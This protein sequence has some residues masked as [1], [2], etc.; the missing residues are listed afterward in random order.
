V[1]ETPAPPI[2]EDRRAA[3]VAAFK[4]AGQLMHK[5]GRKKSARMA[6]AKFG[7]PVSASTAKRSWEAQ[8]ASPVKVGAPLIIPK[9]VENKL[10]ELCLVLREMN[11]PVYKSMVLSYVNTLLRGTEIARK[12]KHHEVRKHWYYNWLSRC[13]R[14]RTANV[15]P[16]ELARAE[17]GT[18]ENAKKHYDLLADV[19][20]STGL[21][22]ER[23]SYDPNEPCCERLTL[24]KPE[25]LFSMLSVRDLM[26]ALA[27]RG[28]QAPKG[29]KKPE[30]LSLLRA[31]LQL[32]ACP[33]V[34][35]I[36]EQSCHDVGLS[37]GDA[38][39]S[40]HSSDVCADMLTC[41]DSDDDESSDSES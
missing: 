26:S 1:E 10:E 24:L 30:L 5:F 8:G 37:E 7:V 36:V 31:N 32:P 12:L 29:A 20:I 41:A 6:S 21:A 33:N 16:L 17:W 13:S 18:S 22:I 15:K 14:L 35:A 40:G 4:Y 9:V 23:A 25:R 19:L 27:F 3:Y 38:G 2:V 28:V 39:P 11:L 34:P